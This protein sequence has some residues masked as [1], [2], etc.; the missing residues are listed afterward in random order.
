MNQRGHKK[1]G[2]HEDINALTEATT[3]L[4][5]HRWKQSDRKFSSYENN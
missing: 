3:T 2:K 4:A 5:S 1:T